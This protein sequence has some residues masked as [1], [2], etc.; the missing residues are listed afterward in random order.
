MFYY[1][2]TGLGAAV[3]NTVVNYYQFAP[4]LQA[5][6]DFM[7]SPSANG[8]EAIT[9]KCNGFNLAAVY[10]I[11]E[12]WSEV[13][14]DYASLDNIRSQ[15]TT[16]VTNVT[17]APMIGASGAVFGLLLAFAMMF[18]DMKL[19]IIF[20][21]IGIK[22]KY[23]VLIYGLAELFLGINDF[24]GDNVAHWAHLG[25]LLAG[26]V[27]MLIWRRFPGNKFFNS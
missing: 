12:H 20:I 17:S 23:F 4:L 7:A 26:I 19:Q 5:Y 25:G 22:A 2:V 18:P 10:E 1:L 27:L 15:V 8:L 21:P 14:A 13:E 24:S 6:N 11:I 3:V 9:Q 16:I